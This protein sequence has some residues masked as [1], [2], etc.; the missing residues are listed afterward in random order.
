MKGLQLFIT[1]LRNCKSRDAEEKRINTELAKMRAK[2]K[3]SKLDAYQ[4]K[5]YMCKVGPARL[6]RERLELTRGSCSTFTSWAGPSRLGTW[7][8]S[9]C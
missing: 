3:D 5:K 2:F 1:D 4:R 8:Q 7:R 9:T 6:W